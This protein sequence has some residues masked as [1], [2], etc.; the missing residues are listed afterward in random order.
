M[1]YEK[2]K[3]HVKVIG[4]MHKN[5]KVWLN[6][7]KSEKTDKRVNIIV[8]GEKGERATWTNPNFISSNRIA[9]NPPNLYDHAVLQQLPKTELLVK[10]LPMI[11][12]S[13][14]SMLWLSRKLPCTFTNSSSMQLKH[15]FCLD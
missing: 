12:Q 7:T 3:H 5:K 1:V 11:S 14:T 2:G 15:R 8:D 10:K 13:A 6:A 9:V 4:G